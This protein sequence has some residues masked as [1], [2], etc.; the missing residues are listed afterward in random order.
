MRNR[1]PLSRSSP[2][3][4]FASSS[5]CASGSTTAA[6]PRAMVDVFAASQVR[7]MNG[8]WIWPTSPKVSTLSGMSRHH[9]AANPAS[10]AACV[11]A[12]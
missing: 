12:T 3:E 5:G 4:R 11:S 1:P 9:T 6:V 8:S 7:Y 10:S 2:A